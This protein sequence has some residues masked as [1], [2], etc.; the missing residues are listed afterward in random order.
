MPDVTVTQLRKQFGD[1]T[2]LDNVDFTI[3][4]GEFFTLLG[5]SGCG[6]STTLNCIAGLE[7]P[8]G[9]S[10]SV[11]DNTFVDIDGGVF[12]PPEGRNLGMVFQSY[13]LWPHKTIADNLAMPLQIRKTDKASQTR[14]IDDALDK[15][16]LLHLRGRYPHQLS[17]GQQQRVALARALVYSP[18]V[19]LLD[20]PLSNLDA[21]LREQARAWLKRLQ[22][23]LGI[24]TVYVTHDQDEALALSDRIAVM[25]GGR[26]LQVATPK[27]IYEAPASAEVAAFV[28]RCNFL[29]ASVD[30]A[31]GSAAVVTLAANGQHI[32]VTTEEAV[33]AGQSVTVAVRPER[34]TVLAPGAEAPAGAN[35]VSAEVLTVSYLG[36]RYEYD[37]GVGDQ[38]VQV[39]SDRGGLTG[40]VQLAIAPDDAR[41]YADADVLSDD[42]QALLTVGH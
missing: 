41:V 4:D 9:G 16:G 10:I 42:A 31:G 21:K 19:L 34:V 6:K 36:S 14:L 25:S 22:V 29:A 20:E 38:I 35:T 28:G 18:N 26:M 30:Q 13:A 27:E 1:N 11:G 17:G 39:V 24:T 8:T 2:V 5:P 12:V 40:R 37:L 15:V 7:R 32:T 3:K 23:E 33:R